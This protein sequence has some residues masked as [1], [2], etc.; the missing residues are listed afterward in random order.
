MPCCQQ[1]PCIGFLHHE[2]L[3]GEH[4]LQMSCVSNVVGPGF[5][6][7]HGGCREGADG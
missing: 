6:P 2:D 1:L 7:W 4:A 5:R 3:V